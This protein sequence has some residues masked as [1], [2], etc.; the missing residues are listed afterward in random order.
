MPAQALYLLNNP[1]VRGQALHFA[2]SLLKETAD[3]A[4]RVRSAYRRA[5]GRP[6]TGAEVSEAREYLDAYA[7]RV[8]AGSDARLAAWQSYCQMLFCLNEFLYVD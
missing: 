6:P 5:L 3:E 1:F 7:R 8:K 2:R 4:G